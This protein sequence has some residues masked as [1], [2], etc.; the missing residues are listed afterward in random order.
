[1]LNYLQREV[2]VLWLFALRRAAVTMNSRW[3]TDIDSVYRRIG[4]LRLHGWTV[5]TVASN[6]SQ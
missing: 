5:C 1:M 6:D 4:L 3:L 2:H